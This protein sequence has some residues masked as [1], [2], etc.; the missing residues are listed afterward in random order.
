MLLGSVLGSTLIPRRFEIE[1]AIALMKSPW[2]LAV[3]PQ[4]Q[5][6]TWVARSASTKMAETSSQGIEPELFIVQRA[7]ES[8]PAHDLA[9]VCLH[10]H[11]RVISVAT[12]AGTS[13]ETQRHGAGSRREA[14]GSPIV[15]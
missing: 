5:T 14:Y 9:I 3:S 1:Q 15:L 12:I 11:R 8:C 7:M 13:S 2:S 6:V 4:L 10:R